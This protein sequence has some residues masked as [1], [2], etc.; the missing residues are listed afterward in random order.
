[1]SPSIHLPTEGP[2]SRVRVSPRTALAAAAPSVAWEPDGDT[3]QLAALAGLVTASNEE[4]AQRAR[5]AI[6][7]VLPHQ[8]LVIVAPASHGLP[9][10]IAAPSEL[11]QRLAAIDWLTIVA[12][13]IPSEEGACRV[14]VPDAVAGLRAAGWG[15]TSGGSRV[16]LIVAAQHKLEIGAEQDWTARLVATLAAACQRGIGQAPSPGTLAFSHAISQ[17]R[18]RVRWELTT[19]HATTLTALLKTLRE[20]ARNG[21]RATPPGVAMA[22]DLT[23][24]ALLEIKAATKR[25]DVSL[26]VPLAEAFAA[27]ETELRALARTGEFRLITGMG[28]PDEDSTL[29]RAIARAAT[30]LSITGA[31]NA[32]NHPGATKLRIHWQASQDA[33]VITVA[34]NGDGFKDDDEQ[35]RSELLHLARRVAS[36]GGTVELDTAPHWGT[37]ITCRLPLRSLTVVPE[38]PAAER[39]SL[40]RPREREVLQLMSAGLRNREIAE[41]LFIT[42]RTVKFHVSNILR[43]F[44]AQSRAELIVLAHNAGITAPEEITSA[45]GSL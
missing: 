33:L 40:L 7:P 16:A 37:S 45:A 25:Q 32:A 31:L 3:R 29:P 27:T 6:T 2:Y 15:A 11:Q 44:D 34:D 36:L 41:R 26:Y 12:N 22:I 8:A 5:A 43:K 18:D 39:I 13:A 14:T 9:V 30:I 17:E 23:S 4:L 20:A 35:A 10:Q 38:T 42:V 1:M 28:G 19:R 21:S 24:Q